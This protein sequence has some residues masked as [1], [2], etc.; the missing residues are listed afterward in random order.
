[1]GKLPSFLRSKWEKQ[2]AE[3]AESNHDCYPSF[4]DFAVLGK[5]SHSKES[6]KHRSRRGPHFSKEVQYTRS[7]VRPDAKVFVSN[8]RPVQGDTSSR[9]NTEKHCQEKM[10]DREGDAQ[11]SPWDILIS[12]KLFLD[13]TKT[14]VCFPRGPQR[15]QARVVAI[16]NIHQQPLHNAISTSSDEFI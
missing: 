12:V 3:Y 5:T 13:D 15:Q 14:E 6:S 4:H 8:T 7:T 11:S 2:V 10:R 16:L 1:M 9:H